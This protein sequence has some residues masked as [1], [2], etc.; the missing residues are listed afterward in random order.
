MLRSRLTSVLREK[1]I[2]GGCQQQVSSRSLH[3]TS[4]LPVCLPFRGAASSQSLREP[5]SSWGVG[6]GVRPAPGAPPVTSIDTFP[7]PPPSHLPSPPPAPLLP[8]QTFKLSQSLARST[9]DERFA[10]TQT[11]V[12]KGPFEPAT[13]LTN[14]TLA[15]G[16]RAT[17]NV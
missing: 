11:S 14:P 12:V 15:P 3:S 13:H 6:V 16:D 8:Y 9:C 1:K 10:L 17:S 2:G 7:P 5:T 4:K